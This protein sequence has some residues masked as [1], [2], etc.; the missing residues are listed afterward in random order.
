MNGRALDALDE[1]S[2][3]HRLGLGTGEFRTILLDLCD[4]LTATPLQ[5]RG[6]F[7]RSNS[8]VMLQLIGELRD[9]GMQ[10]EVIDLCKT[11]MLADGNVSEHEYALLNTLAKAWK[12][13]AVSGRAHGYLHRVI[14]R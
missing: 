8:D 13:S 6:N 2:L 3:S 7:C 12:M 10:A 9:P 11:A 1:A 5:N 4:D 14:A